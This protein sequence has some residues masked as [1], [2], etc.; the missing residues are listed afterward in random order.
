MFFDYD[1]T[2]VVFSFEAL[3]IL[4]ENAKIENKRIKVHIKVDTGMGRVGFSPADFKKLQNLD[5]F[6]ENFSHLFVEGV[7]TH[8]SSADMASEL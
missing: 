1:I 2:P 7:M 4:N 5:F 3:Q 8:L 6:I